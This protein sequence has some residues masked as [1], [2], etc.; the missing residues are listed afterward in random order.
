MESLRLLGQS[1]HHTPKASVHL[2]NKNTIKPQTCLS[3]SR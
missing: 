1:I 3:L 2:A